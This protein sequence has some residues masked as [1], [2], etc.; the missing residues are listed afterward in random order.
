MQ[1]VESVRY[2]P[3]VRGRERLGTFFHFFQQLATKD[4]F[5]LALTEAFPARTF[6]GFGGVVNARLMPHFLRRIMRGAT[7]IPTWVAHCRNVFVSPL[8]VSLYVLRVFQGCWD[9]GIHTQLEGV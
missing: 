7:V 2:G 1:C 5:P 8:K 6:A 3:N 9:A 4:P